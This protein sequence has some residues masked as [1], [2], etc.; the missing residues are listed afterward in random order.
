M[1]FVHSL[2]ANLRMRGRSGGA[3]NYK[4]CPL[5]LRVSSSR[6]RSKNLGKCVVFSLK[7][8]EKCV[9]LEN[10]LKLEQ[11]VVFCELCNLVDVVR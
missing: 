3:G 7:N 6:P 9:K 1:Y 11:K 5:Q 10:Y 2:T 8:M 4:S